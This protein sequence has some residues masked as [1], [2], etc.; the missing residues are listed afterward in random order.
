MNLTG[1]WGSREAIAK[2][3]EMH[4]LTEH[5]LFSKSRHPRIVRARHHLAHLLAT[6]DWSYSDIG[7]LL[8]MHHTTI[9]HGIES[10]CKHLADVDP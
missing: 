1:R 6:E 7:R 2:V 3:I 5:E 8:G 10:Y 4:E 9:S